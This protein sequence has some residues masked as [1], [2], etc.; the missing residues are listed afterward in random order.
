M[1]DPKPKEALGLAL[2]AFEG[3]WKDGTCDQARLDVV[4]GVA[5]AASTLLW[6]SGMEMLVQLAS[7]DSSA[8]EAF[9]ALATSRKAGQR[10]AAIAAMDNRLPRAT[11]LDVL[12]AGLLDKSSKVKMRAFLRC[13]DLAAKELVRDMT[14]VALGMEGKAR[15]EAD[16]YLALTR[17]GYV[18]EPDVDRATITIVYPWGSIISSPVLLEETTPERIEAT[19]AR[20]R[21]EAEDDHAW[22]ERLRVRDEAQKKAER[23][24]AEERSR[25]RREGTL[26]PD[27]QKSFFLVDPDTGEI[28]DG[29]DFDRTIRALVTGAHPDVRKTM[30]MGHLRIASGEV[31][32]ADPIHHFHKQPLEREAPR[33]AHEI[34]FLFGESDAH[35]GAVVLRFAEG[36]I[37]SVERAAWTFPFRE[38]TVFGLASGL[39]AIFDYR[40][41]SEL[42]PPRRPELMSLIELEDGEAGILVALPRI[43]KWN[44]A[45]CRASPETGT[46]YSCHWALDRR[47][48]PLALVVDFA[49]FS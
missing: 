45:L 37:A 13:N 38:A 22:G 5:G 3:I 15:E 10:F 17:D 46:F 18:I 30:G 39:A 23:E 48:E 28:S 33:G 40:E 35:V 29:R 19:L 7:R 12:R 1:K 34:S 6:S 4:V 2:A 44:I 47:G 43:R 24:H 41:V 49:A 16:W 26:V 9:L 32:I 8:L 20:L 14:N 31:A 42:D 25:K 36:E 27:E 21:K 11:V